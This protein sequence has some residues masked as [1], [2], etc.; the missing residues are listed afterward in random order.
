MTKTTATFFAVCAL[1]AAP[2]LAGE[3]DEKKPAPQASTQAAQP[4]VPTASG[5]VYTTDADALDGGEMPRELRDALSQ[6]VNTSSEG[7]QEQVLDDGTVVVDLQGRFQSAMV[8]SVGSDGKLV[9]GC[10]ANTPG[11]TCDHKHDPPA[12]AAAADTPPQQT[13]GQH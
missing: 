9:S 2:L 1:V 4:A 7:L 8:V 13:S 11:K 10:Y 6:M 5:M 12:A 3:G